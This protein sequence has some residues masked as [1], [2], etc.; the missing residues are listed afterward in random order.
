[1]DSL[2]KEAKE[3]NPDILAAQKRWQ[4]SL[5]RIPQ[6]KSPDN[7]NVGLTFEKIPRGTLKLDKTM[8]EDRMLSVTQMFPF[9]GKLSLKGKIALVES[10]MAASEYRGKELE[11]INEVKKAYYDLFMNYKEIELSSESLKLLEAITKIAEARY[12]V[13]E[14]PQEDLFKLN[15]EIAELSNK[16]QNLKQEQEA[17][18]ARLN[19]LLSRQPESSL[20]VPEINEDTAFDKDINLL[21]KL[22]ITNSPELIIFSYAIEKNKYAKSLAQRSFF[23]D[24]MAG[25]VQRGISSGTVGPWDL[26]LAFTVPFWFW[27]KQ[28]YEVKEAIANLEEAQAAYQAIQNKALAETRNLFSKIAIAKNKAKL[29]QD[30]LIPILEA[31]INSSLAALRS[32]KGDLMILLDNIRMLIETKMNYYQALVEYNMNLADL[33]RLIGADLKEVK[34]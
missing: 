9:I 16:I 34:K 25:I 30:N 14:I 1:M 17:K 10:Q 19:T 6:A 4:A 22:T 11:I 23:P 26:M 12:S 29:S 3:K 27:T 20:G 7:P 13:G 31:S 18:N 21:Y 24:I 8:S 28:R 2:I 32:G 5:T 33:E 15:L